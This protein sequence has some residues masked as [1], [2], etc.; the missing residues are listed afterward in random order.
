MGFMDADGNIYNEN[1]E[2]VANGCLDTI[3]GDACDCDYL[4]ANGIDICEYIE[5]N[6]MAGVAT[7]DC[8]GG[9]IDNATECAAG[10]D[11]TEALDDDCDAIIAAGLDICEIIEA[12]PMAPIATMDCDGGGIDN[13]TECAAGNDPTE[14]LDDDCDAIIAAGL[15]LSLIHI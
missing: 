10:N 2:Y 4:I 5:A 11:P 12:N 9:G 14:A 6:P 15:D 13:A 8:D 7:M 3:I 1:E